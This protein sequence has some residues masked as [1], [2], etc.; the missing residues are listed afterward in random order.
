MISFVQHVYQRGNG[1]AGFCF[2]VLVATRKFKDQTGLANF[3]EGDLLFLIK[4]QCG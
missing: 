3:C 2:L 1:R 4:K